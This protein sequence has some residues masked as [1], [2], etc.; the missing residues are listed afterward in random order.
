VVVG[1]VS[2]AELRGKLE[3]ALAAWRGEPP[4]AAPPPPPPAPALR[5]VLIE[6]P[7]APQTFLMLGMPGFERASPDYVAAEVAFQILGGGSAS[8]LFRNLRE[9]KGYTYGIYARGEARKLGGT[10]FVVGS[11]KAD[12]TGK[13]LEALLE[14]LRRLRETPPSAEELED[15]RNALVL[16]LPADFATAGGIASKL[17]EEVVYGLP[18]DYW[19]RYVAAVEKVGAED[20]Q[21]VARAYLDPARLTAVMVGEPATV[22]P[23]LTGLP[24]GP[25]E[26]RPPPGARPG[27]RPPPAKPARRPAQEPH[28][29]AR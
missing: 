18:D 25:L 11:V 29:E 7:A 27:A 28:A 12:V 3:R 16:S 10:A 13:A 9:D 5:T 8:R 21:R 15:A 22:R 17:A 20:V 6:K 26:V 2:E 14:E 4:P 24:L 23:Q 1:D 19:D